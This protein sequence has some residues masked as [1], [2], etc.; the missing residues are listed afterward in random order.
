MPPHFD[1]EAEF[2]DRGTYV[3]ERNLFNNVID[4]HGR[5]EPINILR[6]LFTKDFIKR[7]NANYAVREDE[8]VYSA[9]HYTLKIVTLVLSIVPLLFAAIWCGINS[10][11][12][13]SVILVCTATIGLA[14]FMFVNEMPILFKL[15][16]C[17]M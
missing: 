2:F 6:P 11:N 14:V 7:L 5:G 4:N 10:G 1:T 12:Y 13:I 3:R 9:R 17:G 8:G 16:W 15:V